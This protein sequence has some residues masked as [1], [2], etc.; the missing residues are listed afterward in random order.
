MAFMRQLQR[1]KRASVTREVFIFLAFIL[2]TLL[3]TWPW[4]LRLRDAIPDPGD[5]YVHAY[6]LWWDYHQTFHDP[7]HLFEATMFYPY[8]QTLAF[9][10]ND[11]GIALLFFPFFALGLRPLTVYI[12]AT[13]FGFA[14]TAYGAFRLAR[15][16]DLSNGAA[17]VAGIVFAFVPYRF[18][19]LSHLPIIFT[20][21]V[22]L[23]LEALVLFM[24]E[25]SWRR[26]G[27]L[28]LAFLMNALTCLTWFVL[29]AI[30]LALSAL[31]LMAR[32]RAWR[33]KAF[34]LRGVIA[35]G[36]ALLVLFPF[37]LPYYRVSQAHG[38]IR[39]GAEVAEYS[40]RFI[41]WLAVEERN[42]LWRGLGGAAIRNEMVLFP[43]LLP[44]LLT[45]AAL[46]QTPAVAVRPVLAHARIFRALGEINWTGM[47]RRAGRA[48]A[49]ALGFIWTGIGFLG[50][51]GLNSFF[52]RALYEYIP[53]FRSMRVAARWSMMAYL[54]LALLSGLGA[55]S[56]AGLVLRHWSNLRTCVTYALIII[57]LLCE[58][59]V[60]PLR[61]MRGEADPD[62]L[63]LRLKETSMKGGLVELPAGPKRTLYM[64]RAADHGHPLVTAINSFVPPIEQE[65]ESL[66][67]SRPVPDRLLELCESIPVSYLTIHNASL[68]PESR[69]ALES[70][71]ARA[72]AAGR[73]RF[74]RSYGDGKR[75]T[76]L[77]AVTKTEPFARNEAPLPPPLSMKE[78]NEG[79][80]DLPLQFQETGF[81]IYR[82]YKASYGRMPQY[83]EFMP[84]ARAIREGIEQDA[85]G[86]AQTLESKERE[87][88]ENWTNRAEF[89]KLFEGRSDEEYVERLWANMGVTPD[90]SEKERLVRELKSG[91]ETRA[92]VLLLAAQNEAFILR[93]FNSAFVLMHYFAYLKRDPEE[94]G[95]KFWLSVINSGVEPGDIHTEFISST[96][97]RLKAREP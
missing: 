75:R 58:Q 95:H 41:N 80:S 29:T 2:L 66:T 18:N 63:T 40:A 96:E 15:T 44:L 47:F 88:A 31:F 82:L 97:S 77:Y 36:A 86:G 12:L 93:E 34:W 35:T 53:L 71:L 19:Q 38:F 27:W 45:L 87:F 67:N 91:G 83:A 62:Q 46:F 30:P 48:E 3:M 57:L 17:W 14:F 16:L 7:L 26:A 72:T 73:L 39:S 10:E 25:R 59:R 42:K 89:K 23:L 85:R 94:D 76:D 8:H 24:R 43:G 56:L 28:G 9:S 37:L 11:Y 69:A 81:F 60:A 49:F 65:I 22:P 20:G 5:P 4:A 52:H 78:I 61:L 50:S 68:N 90:A 92:S 33:E 1:L 70:F 64:A 13:L 6:F 74:I 55:Q 51:F 54:G 79:L 84:D 21:W 32:Y